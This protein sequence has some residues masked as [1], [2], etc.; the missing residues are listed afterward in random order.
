MNTDE[1]K[2]ETQK[3][4][5]KAIQYNGQIKNKKEVPNDNPNVQK[6]T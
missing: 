1:K 3:N 4:L 6:R 2:I 5:A